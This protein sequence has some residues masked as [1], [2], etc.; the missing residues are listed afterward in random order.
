MTKLMMIAAATALL[1]TGCGHAPVGMA[2]VS[3]KTA[4]PAAK[5]PAALNAQIARALAP[6][7]PNTLI[8]VSDVEERKGEAGTF[9]FEAQIQTRTHASVTVLHG[10]FNVSSH[11][12]RVIDSATDAALV[13]AGDS[14]LDRL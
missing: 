5:T 1:L 2:P 10:D 12:V 11:A 13:T 9:G 14:N 6:R 8:Q 3:L 4:Q 7:F